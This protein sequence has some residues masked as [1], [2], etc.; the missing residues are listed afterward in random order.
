MLS[1][2]TYELIFGLTTLHWL[3]GLFLFKIVDGCILQIPE[4][5]DLKL[6]PSIAPMASAPMPI[7]CNPRLCLKSHVNQLK[8]KGE[9]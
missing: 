1:L 6:P 2:I 7:L 8:V 4:V 9:I 3:P 5:T